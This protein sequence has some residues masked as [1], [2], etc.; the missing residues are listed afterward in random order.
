MFELFLFF[1][2]G[3]SRSVTRL[4][5]SGAI[6]VHGN[7][8]LSDSSDSP[9]SASRVAGTIGTCHYTQLI[10]VF[11]VETGFHHVARMVSIS[12]PH[13]PPPSASQSAGITGVSHHTRP[14]FWI[15]TRG[16]EVGFC[17]Y[18]HWCLVPSMV[19]LW[20]AWGRGRGLWVF[21]S[22]LNSS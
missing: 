3:E 12:R 2:E 21:W 6:L 22:R 13:D 5:C 16:E 9:A 14:G 18:L 15:F 19:Q 7:L 11:L 20:E 4:K 1:L 8:C 17:G 10:F